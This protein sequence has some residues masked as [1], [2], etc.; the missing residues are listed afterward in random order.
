MSYSLPEMHRQTS[1]TCI[2]K[3]K[4]HYAGRMHPQSPNF[5]VECMSFFL[6]C[7]SSPSTLKLGARGDTSLGMCFGV[8]VAP[9]AYD[10]QRY[11]L[12]HG[13]SLEYSGQQY[14]HTGTALLRKM[15]RAWIWM[16]WIWTQGK[17]TR[18]ELRPPNMKN[19]FRGTQRKTRKR[20]T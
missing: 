1:W 19:M 18:D 7:H 8:V 20:S 16:L 3:A 14:A 2:A 5:N 17:F 11:P 13:V 12:P 9:Y 4:E 6:S 10:L 15:C